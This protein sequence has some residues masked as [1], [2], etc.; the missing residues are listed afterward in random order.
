M[1]ARQSN[2]TSAGCDLVCAVTQD[3]INDVMKEYLDSFAG[4]EFTVYLLSDSQNRV[5]SVTREQAEEAVGCD[6]FTLPDTTGPQ[7]PRLGKLAQLAFF[8]AF[9]ATPGLPGDDPAALPDIVLLDRGPDKIRYRLYCAELAIVAYDG[10]RFSFTNQS[11][12][13]GEP[14]L[15]EFEANLRPG[16][17]RIDSGSAFGVQQLALNFQN[18]V[19][20]RSPWIRGIETRD[21]R[22]AAAAQLFA[23]QYWAHLAAAE[24]SPGAPASPAPTSLAVRVTPHG[25]HPGLS[26]LDYR[27]MS[28]HRALPAAAPFGW[29]WVD[30]PADLDSFAGV[31]AIARETFVQALCERL[32]PAAAAL[33]LDPKLDQFLN[34]ARSANPAQWR[35]V[36]TESLFSGFGRFADSIRD[37]IR[38]PPPVPL[39]T[40]GYRKDVDAT[41]TFWDE[42]FDAQCGYSMF[43][44][45]SL[46]RPANLRLHLEC[47]AHW[48]VREPPRNF[49]WGSLAN[50]WNPWLID[51]DVLKYSVDVDFAL[52]VG[53]G[54]HLVGAM[55]S[56]VISDNAQA[57]GGPAKF[58]NAA[59]YYQNELRTTVGNA[60]Q[61]LQGAL[62][63]LGSEAG[64]WVLPGGGTFEFKNVVFS[65]SNDL[66]VHLNYADPS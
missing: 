9:K 16:G 29:N 32:N 41:T 58:G 49:I 64:G 3:G 6:P 12:P 15:F 31:M 56:P 53:Q 51:C 54:G 34:Y 14:W 10:G 52:G 26:T 62:A 30:A 4:A 1:G 44:T 20:L 7:D 18:P 5:T 2:L 45:V 47:A 28:D 57:A 66:V 55:G 19:M 46:V 40:T 38:D 23:G 43:G 13:E 61:S 39:L 60:V 37:A 63:R 36:R 59:R 35:I 8:T 33:S 11:Q 50:V 24:S 25:T 65:D 21:E 27:L 42:P 48:K 17:A 22:F